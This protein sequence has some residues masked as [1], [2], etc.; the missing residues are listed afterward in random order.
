MFTVVAH[1]DSM[2]VQY[3]VKSAYWQG[4]KIIR[5]TQAPELHPLM[6]L[7]EKESNRFLV[8][9]YLAIDTLERRFHGITFTGT[10]ALPYHTV[11]VDPRVVPL[12]SWLFIEGCGWFRAEDT[13]NMIIGNRL[14]ICVA[15]RVEAVKWGIKQKRVWVV[16]AT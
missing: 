15:T 9:A 10:V 8:T 1:K 3:Q 2:I 11:A 16:D 14:D 12:G 6:Q 4:F 5:P 7:L 13:G